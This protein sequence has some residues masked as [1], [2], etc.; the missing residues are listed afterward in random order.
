[1][2]NQL[3]FDSEMKKYLKDSK[4]KLVTIAVLAILVSISGP[5]SVYFL[6]NIADVILVVPDIASLLFIFIISKVISEAG[7][8]LYTYYKNCYCNRFSNYMSRCLYKIINSLPMELISE[9]PAGDLLDKFDIVSSYSAGFLT[10]L[11]VIIRTLPS[12]V[13][14]L[15]IVSQTTPLTLFVLC[16]PLPLWFGFIF[17]YRKKKRAA[18]LEKSKSDSGLYTRISSMLQHMESIVAFNKYVYERTRYKEIHQDNFKK[19]TKVYRVNAKKEFADLLLNNLPIIIILLLLSSIWNGSSSDMISVCLIT[20]YI[21]GPCISLV[22]VADLCMNL[23]IQKKRLNELLHMPA[24]LNGKIL[25]SG[26]SDVVYSLVNVDYIWP[27]TDHKVLNN[28]N[29]KIKK[30]SCIAI[31]GK[32]GSGKTT[33]LKLLLGILTP[34]SGKIVV[35]GVP[36]TDLDKES[37]LDKISYMN[38]KSQIFSM[39]VQ[40]NI[41]LGLKEYDQRELGN[42][43]KD[44]NI[45]DEIKQMEKSYNTILYENGRNISQGQ[46]QRIAM[47]R[48]LIKP[49]DIIIFDEPTSSVDFENEDMFC[50]AIKK[51]KGLKTIII[52]SHR[53]RLLELAD[54]IYK[55]ENGFLRPFP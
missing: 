28:I 43:C 55:L 20:G 11:F 12:I 9:L 4:L 50:E 38:Q 23:K 44:I 1:M 48:C 52:V 3:L 5:I 8:V 32:S 27:K 49:S 29:I 22:E 34:S 30:G 26:S 14:A 24:K 45:D 10:P 36:M 33:L 39:S 16:V 40:D 37:L 41:V 51:Y 46:A 17:W 18:L 7:D 35:D 15:L 53:E 13:M 47:A 19:E 25:Y 42:I 21:Y 6:R 2:N 31:I 54:E